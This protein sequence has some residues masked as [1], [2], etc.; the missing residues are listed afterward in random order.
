MHISYT[1]YVFNTLTYDRESS[2]SRCRHLAWWRVSRDV[3]DFIQRVRRRFPQE[4]SVQ[5]IEYVRVIERHQDF[6]PHAHVLLRF[7]VVVKIERGRYFDTHF[8]TNLQRCWRHGHSKPEVLRYAGRPN[9]AFNYVLK[10]FLKQFASSTSETCDSTEDSTT[11]QQHGDPLPPKIWDLRG[12]R[13]TYFGMPIRLL[14][15][16]RG[17]QNLYHDEQRRQLGLPNTSE[18]TS[19][20]L[21]LQQTCL[22]S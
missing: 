3:S 7:P 4:G 14:A 19:S 10:Y 9:F 21:R 2:E 17:M 22:D 20:K 5:R 8:Y 18:S 15:W 6:Y 1:H 11:E 12:K 16:S 13:V